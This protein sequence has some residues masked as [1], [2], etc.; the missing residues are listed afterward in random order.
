MRRED[1]YCDVSFIKKNKLI[2]PK[3]TD[4]KRPASKLGPKILKTIPKVNGYKQNS[5]PEY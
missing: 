3:R 4:S 1:V 2:I 5:F